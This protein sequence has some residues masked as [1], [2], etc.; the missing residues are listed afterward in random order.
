MQ[1]ARW[2]GFE[3][4]TLRA[5]QALTYMFH[6]LSEVITVKNSKSIERQM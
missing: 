1:Y 6:F 4:A 3:T 5:S 2:P